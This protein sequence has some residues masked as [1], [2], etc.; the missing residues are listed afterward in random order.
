MSRRHRQWARRVRA[1]HKRAM[2]RLAWPSIKSAGR[3]AGHLAH[4]VAAQGYAQ[5]RK[6]G[7]KLARFVINAQQDAHLHPKIVLESARSVLFRG[8]ERPVTV[9]WPSP[10][11]LG[12]CRQACSRQ[13][14]RRARPSRHPPPMPGGSA[15]AAGSL[16]TLA[17]TALRPRRTERLNTPE[18]RTTEHAT[19]RGEPRWTRS[20]R[21]GSN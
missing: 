1:L 17:T 12:C 7:A 8:M 2:D 15:A 11:C 20:G 18:R 14:T 9:A 6:N 10:G 19:Q 4:R 16:R 3:S 13:T 5:A 21:P